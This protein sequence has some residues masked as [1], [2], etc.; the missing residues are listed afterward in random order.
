MPINRN[1]LTKEQIQ[2]G[3]QTHRVQQGRRA[4]GP[5]PGGNCALRFLRPFRYKEDE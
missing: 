1:E 2:A 4:P 5:E 3:E